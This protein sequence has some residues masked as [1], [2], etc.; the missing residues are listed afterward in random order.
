MSFAVLPRDCPR[1]GGSGG[2]Q[3]PDGAR[4][5]GSDHHLAGAAQARARQA[6][7]PRACLHSQV[8]IQVRALLTNRLTDRELNFEHLH[9]ISD[10]IYIN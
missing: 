2:V 5:Q 9:N 3:D 10:E 8:A 1:D 4:Q 7:A 6:A